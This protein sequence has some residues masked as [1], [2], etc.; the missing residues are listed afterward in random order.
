MVAP[1]LGHFDALIPTL[2]QLI[3]G[4]QT[5]TIKRIRLTRTILQSELGP[6]LETED[7]DLL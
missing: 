5:M 6:H 1:P 4:I 3:I 2:A 7:G